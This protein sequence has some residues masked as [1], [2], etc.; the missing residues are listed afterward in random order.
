[1]RAVTSISSAKK[2]NLSQIL[3][4]LQLVNLPIEGVAEHLN[5]FFII[6]EANRIAGN[7]LGCVGLEIYG[8]SALLRSVAVRPEYQGEGYGKDLTDRAIQYARK[9]GVKALFLLTDTAE[10]YFTRA[11][12]VKVERDEVPPEVKQSVEF[13]SLCP[14]SSACMMKKI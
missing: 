14:L 8:G 3:A 6:R 1:M 9:K 7:I 13:T 4:L 2:S 12:F 5:D 11:G 10:N